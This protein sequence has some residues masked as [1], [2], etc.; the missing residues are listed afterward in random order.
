[1]REVEEFRA[2]RVVRCAVDGDGAGR[3]ETVIVKVAERGEG[4]VRGIGAIHNEQ[5]A[6]ELL[7]LAGSDVAAGLLASDAES[8]VLVLEDMG[9]GP[10]LAT[11]LLGGDEADAEDAAVASARALGTLHAQTIGFAE[12][13]YEI[14]GRLGPIDREAD[15]FTLRGTDLRTCV[16]DL[17]AGCQSDVDVVLQELAEPEDFLTLSGGDPCP[18]NGRLGAAGF[19]F[20]DFEAASCRHALVDAAHYVMPFPNCWCWRRLPEDLASR[21]LDTHREELARASVQ[22]ADA[23]RY[24]SALA[25]AAGAWAIWTMDRRLPQVPVDEVA[26]TR[27]VEALSNFARYAVDHD[28]L[29]NLRQHCDDLANT[30]SQRWSVTETGTYPAFGGPPWH[31]PPRR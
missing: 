27:T 10:S 23:D 31:Q 30:I 9:D 18:D 11:A 20:F 26:R 5:A 28:E 13:Y 1:L 12:S 6:L 14:R 17:P 25:R 2:G 19:R 29:P 4:R 3:G 16:A 21:M 22:A 8:G 7:G 15:L 24:A